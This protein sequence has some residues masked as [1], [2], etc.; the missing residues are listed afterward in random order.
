LAVAQV[1]EGPL[2]AGLVGAEDHLN[3]ADEM[4]ETQI[5][6]AE[7]RRGV[8]PGC[9]HFL[10]PPRHRC[11]NHIDGRLPG[12]SAVQ[13]GAGVR[14]RVPHPL[15]PVDGAPQPA[16][17]KGRHLGGAVPCRRHV[18]HLDPRPIGR[19]QLGAISVGERPE[20][21]DRPV[22]LFNCSVQRTVIG[23]GRLETQAAFQLARLFSSHLV[24]EFRN[25]RAAGAVR[26]QFLKGND[27]LQ[28]E[29]SLKRRDKLGGRNMEILAP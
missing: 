26:V 19:L 25:R 14:E 24:E 21:S 11:G 17:Q 18:D 1:I 10:P 15:R 2:P 3:L 8:G 6:R 23:P 27:R 22:F 16:A 9:V 13:G 20:S 28:H 5:E 29:V 12:E 7:D 4:L